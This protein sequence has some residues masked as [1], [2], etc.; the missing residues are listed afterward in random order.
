[1]NLAS[2]SQGNRVAPDFD[3]AEANAATATFILL[4]AAGLSG[5]IG[6]QTAPGW[7]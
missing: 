1:V 7:Q 5:R 6:D 4:K 3:A 2:L